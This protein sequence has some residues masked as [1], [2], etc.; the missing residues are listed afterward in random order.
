M[1]EN[2]ESQQPPADKAAQGAGG[3]ANAGDGAPSEAP[4]RSVHTTNFAQLLNHFNASLLVTTYQAGKLVVVR[5]DGDV[6]NTHFR[7]FKKPMGMAVDGNRLAIGTAQEIWE[8]RNVPAVA[9]R[10]EPK[11]KVDGCF[12]PCLLYTSPSPR[13]RQKSR[14]PSSA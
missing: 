2:D 6:I 7:N 1:T 10:L 8:F 5:S 3:D 11:G 13:D 4:L 14:M 12:M 9:P